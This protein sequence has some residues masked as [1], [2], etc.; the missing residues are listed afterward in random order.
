MIFPEKLTKF[1]NFTWFLPEKCLNLIL[2]NNCPK[3]IFPNFE[4]GG[5]VPPDPRLLRLCIQSDYCEFAIHMASYQN[6]ISV[7]VVAL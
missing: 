7:T 3:N 6:C 4:G 1:P 5:N 2:H